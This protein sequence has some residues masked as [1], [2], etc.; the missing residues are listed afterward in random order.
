MTE[1]AERVEPRRN[2]ADARRVLDEACP[3]KCCAI[4]GLQIPTCLTIAHLDQNPANNAAENLAR[5]CQ[6]HHWMYDAG[7]YPAE[8]IRL[9]QAHWQETGG[10]PCHDAR[11]KGAGKRAGLTRRRRAAARKA[12]RTR[13]AAAALLRVDAPPLQDGPAEG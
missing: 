12:V 1:A 13:E 3:F 11:L 8:A 5:L 6:T 9:L 2:Q 10:V 7:L 4:C